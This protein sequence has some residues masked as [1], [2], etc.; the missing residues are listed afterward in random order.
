MKRLFWLI[1]SPRAAKR[2]VNI[3][4]LLRASRTGRREHAA[5]VGGETEGQHRVALLLL[6]IVTAIPTKPP[7]FCASC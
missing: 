2:F 6:A 3:Y 7:R 4:R 1:P 5:F